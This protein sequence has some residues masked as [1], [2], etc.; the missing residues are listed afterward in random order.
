MCDILKCDSQVFANHCTL[1]NKIKDGGGEA[2][3]MFM[4]DDEYYGLL[5]T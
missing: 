2:I 3:D 4:M 1:V 5:Y